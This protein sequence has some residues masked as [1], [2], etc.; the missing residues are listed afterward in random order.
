[1]EVIAGAAVSAKPANVEKAG[2]LVQLLIGAGG[3]YSAFLFYG[4][5]QEAIFHFKTKG[6]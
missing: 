3:I 4:L 2:S 6:I 5:Y 1:L